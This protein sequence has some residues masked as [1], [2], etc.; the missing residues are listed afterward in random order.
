MKMIKYFLVPILLLS[1]QSSLGRSFTIIN[2]PSRYIACVTNTAYD[3]KTHK[4]ADKTFTVATGK[5]YVITDQPSR[6]KVRM[7]NKGCSDLAEATLAFELP[8]TTF[9]KLNVQT[10]AGKVIFEFS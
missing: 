8:R 5:S 1:V 6:L 7:V 3:T 4:Y 2:N 9:D 10:G